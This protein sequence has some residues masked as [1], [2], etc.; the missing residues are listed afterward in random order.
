MVLN[1]SR[2]VMM[3]GVDRMHLIYMY[4]PCISSVYIQ[5]MSSTPSH[6][7]SLV[8]H[9]HPR[10]TLPRYLH[11]MSTSPLPTQHVHIKTGHIRASVPWRWSCFAFGPHGRGFS[12]DGVKEHLMLHGVREHLILPSTQNNLC[13]DDAL[14]M[15]G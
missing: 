2:H 15:C 8:I 7:A 13:V 5:C 1:V 4:I 11:T 12:S 6:C 14:R 9:R 3:G 10:L